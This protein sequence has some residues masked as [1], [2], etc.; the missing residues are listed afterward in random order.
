[1]RKPALVLFDLGNVLVRFTPES[2]WQTLSL[3]GKDEK[4]PY[5]ADVKEA[6]EKFECGKLKTSEFFDELERIFAGRF[7]REHLRRA[8]A[9]VLTDPIPETEKIVSKVTQRLSTAL[10]SNTN[11]FHYAY[12]MDTLPVMKLLPKHYLSYKLGVMKPNPEFYRSVLHEEK[13]SSESTVFIDDVEENVE[14]AQA[15]GMT[16]VRF[17]NPADLENQFRKLHIL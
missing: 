13:V 3:Y 9:S 4:A 15:A 17:K 16:G 11:E 10:V 8:T 2:F 7:R 14:G 1:M 12:C 6:G 5:I